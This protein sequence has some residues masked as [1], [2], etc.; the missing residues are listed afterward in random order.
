MGKP[1][2]HALLSASASHRWMQCPPSARL[3]ESY[4]SKGSAYAAEGTDAHSLCEFKLKGSLGIPAPDP[5]GDLSYYNEEMEEY[6]NG[7]A[8]FILE[9]VE[10]A[11]Q[12]RAD[13]IVLIEHRLD[14]SRYVE[15]GFGT[16]DCVVIADGTLHI[17]DYKHG[18]GVLVEAED[19]PQ[20]M[21]YALGALELFDGIYDINT[22]SMT[23]YQPRRDNVSTH[24]VFKDSLYQWAEDVLKPAAELAYAGDGEFSCGEWCR[25]CRAK[26]ECRE[27]ANANMALAAYEFAEPAL[28]ENDEIASILARIDELVNW[29]GDIKGFALQQAI[30]GVKFDGFKVVEGRSSRKYSNEETVANTVSAAGFDPYEHKV[31]GITAMEKALGKSRFAELLGG[32]VEKPQGKPAL[33]PEGDKRPAINK[34]TQDFNDYE[35]EKYND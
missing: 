6:A 23:I 11:K 31:M 21:L 16:G 17:V 5:T 28:L 13:P 10:T 33:V 22:V 15:G 19:N 7:Y 32:L 2:G 4:E 3:C 29:A 8:A 25:F 1:Q 20:M 34:A 35:E 14:F 27:R 9:L 26:A 30:K 24:T 12:A 18:Q